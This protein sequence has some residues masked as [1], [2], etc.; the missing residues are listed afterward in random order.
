[1]LG[2]V[3]VFFTIIS[4]FPFPFKAAHCIISTTKHVCVI[5]YN[6]FHVILTQ[7]LRCHKLYQPSRATTFSEP[8]LQLLP[9]SGGDAVDDTTGHRTP[10]S[11]LSFSKRLSSRLLSSL[12]SSAS[13]SSWGETHTHTRQLAHITICLT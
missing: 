2:C 12:S 3:I 13:S 9:G 6:W 1:M 4:S 8:V 7:D 10:S 11:T 5:S